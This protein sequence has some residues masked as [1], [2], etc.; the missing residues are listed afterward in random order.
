MESKYTRDKE[1]VEMIN[2]ATQNIVYDFGFVY[3][4]GS[5][6]NEIRVSI[7][8]DEGYASLLGSHMTPAIVSMEQTL[9]ELG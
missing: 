5:L 6:G 3:N 4:W 1:S 8:K 2:L 7:M 9:E